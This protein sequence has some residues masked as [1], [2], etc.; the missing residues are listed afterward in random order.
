ML[1]APILA[2]L[3]AV[4]AMALFFVAVQF[5]RWR[6]PAAAWRLVPVSL[7]VGFLL[8]SVSQMVMVAHHL[9]EPLGVEPYLEVYLAL[10]FLATIPILNGLSAPA[11]YP[12]SRSVVELFSAPFR[13]PNLVLLYDGVALALAIFVLAVEFLPAPGLMLTL[14]FGLV[15]SVLLL[16]L[17]LLLLFARVRR[18]LMVGVEAFG[19]LA[20][21]LAAAFI[22]AVVQPF[23]ED[24][25]AYSAVSA[26]ALAVIPIGLAAVVFRIADT[27]LLTRYVSSFTVSL[28]EKWRVSVRA[29]EHTTCLYTPRADKYG[30]F[31]AYVLEGL[32]AG[33][34]VLYLHPDDEK[35]AVRQ[36]LL[37][38]GVDVEAELRKG[39]LKLTALSELFPRGI[40]DASAASQFA[41][42]EKAASM[43]GGYRHF[44]VLSDFGNI[45][46]FQGLLESLIDE[47]PKV[48][49]AVMDPFVIFLRAINI[50]S[51]D[52]A[53]LH[54]LRKIHARSFL[55]P[56]ELGPGAFEAFS[57][58]LGITHSELLGRKLLAEF[59][60][61]ASFEGYVEDFVRE[62]LTNDEP[63][64][65]FTKKAG[66]IPLRIGKYRAVR[67][68]CLTGEVS[69]PSE[70]P[71]NFGYPCG[72]GILLPASE[73]SFIYDALHK[74]ISEYP[75]SNI[76]IIFDSISDLM[77]SV[78]G[79]KAFSFLRTALDILASRTI[80]AL[81]LLNPSAH[82][83][84][85][86]AAIRGL[87]ANQLN[88]ERGRIRVIKLAEST[89]GIVEARGGGNESWKARKIGLGSFFSKPL[90][91]R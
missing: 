68:F 28:G 53:Q 42:K 41:E 33:D 31:G 88:L 52:E 24:F 89:L 14:T 50:Q 39:S 81:F 71:R 12:Y 25:F 60:P 72:G 65:A 48:A 74:A 70:C 36:Q 47:A 40:Y 32:A 78:G 3:H 23:V 29:G 75:R 2:V 4:A 90:T 84:K 9:E 30:I 59:D 51:L 26:F 21:L 55:L 57:V 86:V 43:T 87:F 46:K 56:E 64:F 20:G 45:G 13:K 79:E 61:S 6:T 54:A 38:R 19:I 17:L 7:F 22:A 66:A 10:V 27:G 62:A 1:E 37:D 16:L 44:R 63:V 73:L 83:A 8:L 77:L 34:R 80:T 35:A 58:Q 69:R 67:L 85:T 76:V 18:V 82:E 91:K 5:V 49:A 11:Y 15:F